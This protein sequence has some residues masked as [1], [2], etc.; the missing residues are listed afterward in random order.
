M[1]ILED[2]T[3]KYLLY[4][5]AAGGGK[6][7]LG[8]TWQLIR[9][10]RFAGTRGLICRETLV[11]LRE[12]TLQTIFDIFTEWRFESGIDYVFIS[13]PMG[14]FFPNGSQIFLKEL[15]AIPRDPQFTRLGS[16]EVTDVFIDEAAEIAFEAYQVIKTRIRYKLREFDLIPKLLASCNPTK[17]WI[18]ST[19]YLP[20]KNGTLP[21]TDKFLAA[22]WCDEPRL[23]R[24]YV[25][26]L[27]ALTGSLRERLVNGN[28]EYD[29]DP[30]VLFDRESLDNMFKAIPAASSDNTKTYITVDPARQGKDRAVI[31]GWEDLQLT[32]IKVFE[33]CTTNQLLEAIQVMALELKT[34]ASQ[35]IVDQNDAM[36]AAIID[37]LGCKGFLVNARPQET[38]KQ[39][40]LINDRN[41]RAQCVFVMADLVQRNLIGVT[42]KNRGDYQKLITEELEQLKSLTLDDPKKRDVTPKKDIKAAIQRS[43]DFADAFVMRGWFAWRDQHLPARERFVSTDELNKQLLSI[44]QSITW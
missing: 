13:Q 44:S 11:K 27:L 24:S 40:Y 10:L 29:D 4:G 7:R 2:K 23:A 42:S 35:I 36:G 21:P 25:E 8:C 20:E 31:L 34:P 43:P 1:E 5:G 19:F 12:S 18:Y 30:S 26:S 39:N 41:L 3:T 22:S 28:W 14:I 16:L 6:T 32:K 9:R 37:L 38:N 33:K 15:K 17:N